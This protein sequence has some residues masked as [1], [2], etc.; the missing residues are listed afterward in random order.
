M[1]TMSVSSMDGSALHPVGGLM[2]S[3]SLLMY[4]KFSPLPL[5]SFLDYYIGDSAFTSMGVS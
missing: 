2:A 4:D 5:K 3:L 1:F